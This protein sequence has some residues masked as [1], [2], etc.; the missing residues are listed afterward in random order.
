MSTIC[1]YAHIYVVA[2]HPPLGLLSQPGRSAVT[3]LGDTNDTA[4][5]TSTSITRLLAVLMATLS[6]VISAG[7]HN[8]GAPDDALGSNEL[9][10]LVGQ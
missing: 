3:L 9:D 2:S 6:E 4:G 8:N 5:W 10:Q 7:V 1:S